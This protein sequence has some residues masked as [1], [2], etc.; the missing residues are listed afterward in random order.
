MTKQRMSDE[1]ERE[2]WDIVFQ[3]RFGASA[4]CTAADAADDADE[5]IRRRRIT[6]GKSPALEVLDGEE[7]KEN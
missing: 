5:A 3:M 1:E 7:W 4:E 6:L 2:L